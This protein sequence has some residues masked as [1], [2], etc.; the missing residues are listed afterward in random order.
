MLGLVSPEPA[1]GGSGSMEIW[2]RI[3]NGSLGNQGVETAFTQAREG[4][5]MENGF[6]KTAAGDYLLSAKLRINALTKIRAK[7]VGSVVEKGMF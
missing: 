7:M 2:A 5:K 1:Q 3:F 4:D 6:P